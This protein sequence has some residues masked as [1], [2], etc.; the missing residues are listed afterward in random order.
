MHLGQINLGQLALCGWPGLARLWMRG[1]WSALALAIGFSV[2]L[3]IALVATFAW[4]TLLGDTFPAVAWP[5]IIVIWVISVVVSY[6]MIG[7]WSS[8]PAMAAETKVAE[9]G[10]FLEENESDTLFNRAQGEYLKGNWLDAESLL[11]RRLHHNDRDVESRLLLATLYRHT[12]RLELAR[13]ELASLKRFDET[14]HWHFEIRNEYELIRQIE[15]ERLDDQPNSNQET[16]HPSHV[17][18]K[19]NTSLDQ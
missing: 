18:T 5:I 9:K 3:N 10:E 16:L 6:R 2:L 7:S 1:S 19:L 17:Q 12:R 4:P 11:K 8:P 14:I 15:L 13:A